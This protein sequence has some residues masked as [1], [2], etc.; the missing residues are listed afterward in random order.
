MS[1]M[2]NNDKVF[3]GRGWGIFMGEKGAMNLFRRFWDRQI[4]QTRR[5][6]RPKSEKNKNFL[7]FLISLPIND[8]PSFPVCCPLPAV[9]CFSTKRAGIHDQNPKK[10]KKF[11]PSL[12]LYFTTSYDFSS[13]SSC[14]RGESFFDQTRIFAPL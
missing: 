6:S 11:S 13:C 7:Q 3:Y 8:L 12:T 14:L 10:I 9:R 1:T 4:G 5:Y 2:P